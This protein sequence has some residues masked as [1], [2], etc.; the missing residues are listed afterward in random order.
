MSKKHGKICSGKKLLIFASDFL[1]QKM[2]SG[3]D[4]YDVG[5][6]DRRSAHVILR[7]PGEREPFPPVTRDLALF[8]AGDS[9]QLFQNFVVACPP[10]SSFPGSSWWQFWIFFP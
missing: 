10:P 8:S 7:L 3:C 1:G 2:C 9:R 5:F 6:T 4:G